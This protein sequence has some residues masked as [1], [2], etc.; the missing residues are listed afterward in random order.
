[1]SWNLPLQLSKLVRNPY[2]VNMNFL[3]DVDV[4]GNLKVYGNVDISGGITVFMDLS[5]V[6]LDGNDA[7]GQNIIGVDTY[8]GINADLSGDLDVSGNSTIY[9]N[10]DI[11]GGFGASENTVAGQRIINSSSNTFTVQDYEGNWA[12]RVGDGTTNPATARNVLL[13]ASAG[14][15]NVGVDP[16]YSTSLNVYG[17][18]ETTDLSVNNNLDVSGN[19]FIYGF[20][21]V[22]NDLSV[23]NN[24]D[25]SG[26]AF[27]YGFTT[28]NNDLSVNNNLDVSGNVNIFNDCDVSQNLTVFG[29]TNCENN[30]NVKGNCDISGNIGFCNDIDTE[31]FTSTGVSSLGATTINTSLTLTGYTTGDMIYSNSAG[32]IQKLP[33]GSSGQ[34]L[35][36]SGGVPIWASPSLSTFLPVGFMFPYPSNVNVVLTTFGIEQNFA[37]NSSPSF[38]LCDGN[39]FDTSFFFELATVLAS[40][41]TPNMTGKTT[42]GNE[43]GYTASIGTTGGTKTISVAQLPP[44]SHSILTQGGIGVQSD[45]IVHNQS[46]DG[47]NKTY[48][49]GNTG[50]GSNFIVPHLSVNYFIYTGK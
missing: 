36:V 8:S 34:V 37:I 35:E 3:Q 26:N 9:G 48:N 49:T 13:C 17:L 24:L 14:Q 40:N 33:I 4:S 39:I 2:N 10:T 25:V 22:N 29:Q 27:I 28:V 20:T 15:V 43:A 16:T 38:I 31:D 6:L 45:L 19:A 42:F 5:D 46:S 11:Y 41:L 50:S 12:I 30:L 44:H 21:T 7:S 47:T 18:T 1:M 32:V 23:N